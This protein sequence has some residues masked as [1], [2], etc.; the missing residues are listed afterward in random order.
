MIKKIIIFS[1]TRLTHAGNNK[2]AK[3]KPLPIEWLTDGEWK[4][5]LF[6]KKFKK[7]KLNGKEEKKYFFAAMYET[8]RKK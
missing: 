5:F 6:K 1:I 2:I 3:Q 8:G 4:E 7:L